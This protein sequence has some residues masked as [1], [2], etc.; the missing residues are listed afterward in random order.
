MT[1]HGF[2]PFDTAIGR[3]AIAWGERGVVGVQLPEASEL[4]TRARLFRRFGE[5]RESPPT[6]DVQRAVDGIVALLRGEASDLS[7]VVL[8]MD[9]V[10]SF[11][12]RVYEVARTILPGATLS[13]GDIAARLGEPGSARDVG[14]RSAGTHSRS[15]CRAIVWSRRAARSAASPRAAGSGRS[16]T[17]SRSR[18]RRRTVRWRSSSATG[19]RAPGSSPPS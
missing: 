18:A 4:E 6:P 2:L 3:C 14:T 12:R 7:F 16:C 10:P 8:D 9:R 19:S 13:Y 5:P 15:S 17:F 11:H 1:A